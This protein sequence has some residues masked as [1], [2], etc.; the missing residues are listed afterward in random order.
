MG[1]LGPDGKPFGAPMSET[2]SSGPT[3]VSK[4]RKP[5][6]IGKVLPMREK[7]KYYNLKKEDPSETVDAQVVEEIVPKAK[8]PKA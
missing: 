8:T 3:R 4:S 6:K 1:Q 7:S 5:K 2:T